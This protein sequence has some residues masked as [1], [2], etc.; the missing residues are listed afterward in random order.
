LFVN[1]GVCQNTTQ[2]VSLLCLAASVGSHQKKAT[3]KKRT[4]STQ[5]ASKE[6]EKEEEEEACSVYNTRKQFESFLC[7]EITV[8]SHTLPFNYIWNERKSLQL[9]SVVS[10][11]AVINTT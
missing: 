3:Q 11:A 7:A 8:S 2:A 10:F 6:K 9:S 1:F 5:Q 4:L